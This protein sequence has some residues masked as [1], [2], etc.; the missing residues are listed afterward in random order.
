MLVVVP[1]GVVIVPV[2]PVIWPPVG[3]AIATPPPP[4]STTPLNSTIRHEDTSWRFLLRH[5]FQ[6]NSTRPSRMWKLFIARPLGIGNFGKKGTFADV[7]HRA[8][9]LVFPRKKLYARFAEIDAAGR[10][11]AALSSSRDHRRPTSPNRAAI[12][13]CESD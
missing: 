7:R 3:P 9:D 6:R 12:R 11:H 2:P 10:R 1:S 4:S 13:R 8:R 5:R